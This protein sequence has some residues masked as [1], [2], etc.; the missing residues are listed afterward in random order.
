MGVAVNKKAHTD[1]AL[2]AD[3]D[4]ETYLELNADVDGLQVRMV[5]QIYGDSL[6]WEGFCGGSG[7]ASLWIYREDLFA[8]LRQLGYV[9]IRIGFDEPDHQNGPSFAILAHKS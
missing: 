2:P 1:W 9:D 6:G 8:L 5:R 7:A 4:P 3:F